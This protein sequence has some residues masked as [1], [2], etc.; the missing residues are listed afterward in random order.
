MHKAEQPYFIA[1]FG[2]KTN[3]KLLSDLG[4]ALTEFQRDNYHEAVGG[5]PRKRDRLKRDLEDE[6]KPISQKEKAIDA[7]GTDEKKLNAEQVRRANFRDKLRRT[8]T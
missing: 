3:K 2:A 8:K 7:V 6:K 1:M 5:R 4:P